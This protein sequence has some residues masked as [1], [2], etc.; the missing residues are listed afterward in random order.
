MF[1]N[2]GLV[3]RLVAA[4]IFLL[5]GLLLLKKAAPRTGAALITIGAAL[6]VVG[7]LYGMVVLRPFIG[8][9]FVDDWHVQLDIVDVLS[10]V[11]LLICA[12]GLALHAL[13]HPFARR[14]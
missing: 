9:E 14:Y 6:S 2:T 8:R 4:L 12:G 13:R 1:T 5:A 3:I 7:D 11:G 10:T